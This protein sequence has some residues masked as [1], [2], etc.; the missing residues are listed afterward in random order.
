MEINTTR[1]SH[2]FIG[3]LSDL[4]S[5]DMIYV[6]LRP[7]FMNEKPNNSVCSYLLTVNRN[8]SITFVANAT[9][10]FM[11]RSTLTNLSPK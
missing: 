7:F 9:G 11:N 5:V 3:L 2:R 8:I 4:T 6:L 10:L 1:T